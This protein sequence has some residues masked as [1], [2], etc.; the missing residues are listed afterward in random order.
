[1]QSTKCPISDQLSQGTRKL[2]L[3]LSWSWFNQA[4]VSGQVRQWVF[5]LIRA[6]TA[7]QAV[8]VN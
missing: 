3:G 4:A 6:E 8:Y 7:G 2:S 5:M 1:M